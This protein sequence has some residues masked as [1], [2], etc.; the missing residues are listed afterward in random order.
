MEHYYR[1]K[2]VVI[3]FIVDGSKDLEIRVADY[4]R[5]QVKIGDILVFQGL[6]RRTVK[7]IRRYE[8]FEI[9][10]SHE[11][12]SRIMPGWSC[13]MIHNGLRGIYPPEKEKLGVLVFELGTACP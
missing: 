11:N 1:L 6:Y 10:L 5:K 3:P 7:A 8:D 9:M 2:R 13:S 12:H 4:K